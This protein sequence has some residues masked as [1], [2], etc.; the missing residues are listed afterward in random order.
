MKKDDCC[1]NCLFFRLEPLQAGAGTCRVEAP[2]LFMWPLPDGRLVNQSGFP[3]VQQKTWCG[4]HRRN[5]E[6]VKTEEPTGVI[7]NENN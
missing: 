6:G 4:R 2:K 5:L 7:G 3:P 1:A